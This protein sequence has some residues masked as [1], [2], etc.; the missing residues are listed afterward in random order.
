MSK[1]LENKVAI[2][3][4]AGQTPGETVGNGKAASLLFAREGATVVAVDRDRAAAEDTA[5][6]IRAEGGTAQVALA[7][8]IDEASIARVLE[9]C[10]SEHGRVDILHNNVGVS[11]A[12]GD[13]P[14]TD[15][16][17]DAFDRVVAL[18]LKS[19]VLATKHALPIMQEQ[20]AGVILYTASMAVTIDYPNIGYKTSKAGV[21]ALMQSVAIRYAAYGVRANAILPGAINTPIAVE[22]RVGIGGKTREQIIAERDARVPL[23]G[24]QGTAWDV[25]HAA[26]YLASDEAGFV[27]GA[28][29]PV[30]GGQMLRIG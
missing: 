5:S 7:D 26:L 21:I 27:T 15:V 22:P 11:I 25:A 29:L 17:A 18:N 3:V 8:A 2:V 6:A 20:K 23:N 4:G 10:R 28:S 12:A 30:D 13:A 16:E 9:N 19:A 24:K 14:V 1:R